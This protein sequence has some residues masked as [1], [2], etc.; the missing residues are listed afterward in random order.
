M[1]SIRCLAGAW[2][3]PDGTK[4]YKKGSWSLERACDQPGGVES[5]VRL[6]R[7]VWIPVFACLTATLVAEKTTGRPPVYESNVATVGKGMNAY[8]F[9]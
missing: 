7:V 9:E 6:I 3:R 4:L 5:L 8:L 1:D 2:R